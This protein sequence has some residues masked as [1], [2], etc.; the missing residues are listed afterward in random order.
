MI[1]AMVSIIFG[2][3]LSVL[4]EKTRN[5]STPAKA[6]AAI[7]ELFTEKLIE[8]IQR[9]Q[10]ASYRINDLMIGSVEKE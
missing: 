7:A 6:R 1:V 3:L 9:V 4:S 2:V 5:W 8:S 10:D